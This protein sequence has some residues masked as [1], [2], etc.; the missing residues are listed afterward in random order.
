[1]TLETTYLLTSESVSEGHP[2]KV[3]DQISDSVLDY[4]L[5][6]DPLAR[7]ACESLIGRGYL[8]IAGE[9]SSQGLSVGDLRATLPDV[10]RQRLRAIGYTDANSGFAVDDAE[11]HVR[12]GAQAPE[13]ANQVDRVVGKLGAGD[14]GL[15]FGYATRE[16]PERMPLPIA[17]AHRL[18]RRLAALRHDG[19]LPYLRPDAKSQVT[20]RY[21]GHRP[22]GVDTVVVATQHAPG[23]DL[24]NV[25]ADVSGEVIWPCLRG[26]AK[27]DSVRILVN[28]AG[29]FVKGGPAAD[30]G[31]TGRKIIV[32]TYGGS[33]PHGG[34]A[35]SGKDATKVD[36]SAAYAARWVARHIVDASLALRATVQLAYAIGSLEPVS[37]YVTTHGTGAVQDAR[38][39]RAVQEVFDLSPAG[40]IGALELRRPVFAETAAYGHFGR[41][42]EAFTWEQT[43]HLESL[44]AAVGMAGARVESD[45]GSQ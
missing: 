23:V 1:M 2:D 38:L 10:A 6:H 43:P 36:R 33:C 32:D 39:A 21:D 24:D 19:T 16:T 26:F 34:G 44:Q 4:V 14:Q 41:E 15:M 11:I 22:V 18:L 25:R 20:V 27:P 5:G 31:L 3:A 35:F 13:I 29:S 7:V 8:V 30:T 45:G 40:I 37:V 12:I 28:H 17:L 9:V 42:G